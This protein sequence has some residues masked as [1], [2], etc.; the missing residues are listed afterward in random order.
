[1]RKGS[2]GSGLYLLGWI[3]TFSTAAVLGAVVPWYFA[4]APPWNQIVGVF[5]QR[6]LDGVV[7]T[8][9]DGSSRIGLRRDRG[10]RA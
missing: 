5:D 3:V 8:R 9:H 1:M 7:Q 6:G 4:L 10:A 2:I